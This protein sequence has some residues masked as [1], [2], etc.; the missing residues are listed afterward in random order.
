MRG[1][2]PH[3]AAE[4][5]SLPTKRLLAHLRRLQICEGS[6]AL[7]DGPP[8]GSDYRP[9]EFIYFKDDPRWS[10]QYA[11]LKRILAHREHVPKAPERKARRLETLAKNQGKSRERPRSKRR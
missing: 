1:V 5:E 10:Q 2:R 4:L 7:S 8:F 6:I 3:A 9:E 11:E